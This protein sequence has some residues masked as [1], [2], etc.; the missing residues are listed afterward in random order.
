MAKEKSD[1]ERE[2]L[3]DALLSWEGEVSNRRLQDLLALSQV[4]ASQ[5]LREYRDAHPTRLLL[6]SKEK[7]YLPAKHKESA[8]PE[9]LS[10]Y[11]ALVGLPNRLDAA[12]SDHQ[13][14]WE[15]FPNISHPPSTA[16]AELSRA[17]KIG[18]MVELGYR[19][20]REP[21]PHSRTI[22]PHSLVRA[23]RRWHVR[24]YCVETAD[25][26]DFALRRIT[27]VR[28]IGD[29]AEKTKDEDVAWNSWAEIRLIAHPELNAGQQDLV[30]F[31]YFGGTAARVDKCRGAL[32]SYFI[33]DVRA[34]T[35]LKVQKPPEYQLAVENLDSLKKWIF[36][37]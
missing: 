29:V 32:V 6:D 14:H 36:R 15:A 13:I 9:S 11:L 7:R 30:R 21:T 19:S 8:N 31:E 2:I 33:Q 28:Q 17:I 34:A 18:Q 10:Q 24:G 20:M 3:I 16:F 23:G 35:D 5:W 25:F 12:T 1:I 27:K 26:R 22:A 37:S 4:R